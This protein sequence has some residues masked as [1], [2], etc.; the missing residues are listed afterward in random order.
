MSADIKISFLLFPR[1]IELNGAE[2]KNKQV[3]VLPGL[4]KKFEQLK[5]GICENGIMYKIQILKSLSLSL[6][7]LLPCR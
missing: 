6:S 1:L 2:Y 5:V 3:Q 4:R 7:L